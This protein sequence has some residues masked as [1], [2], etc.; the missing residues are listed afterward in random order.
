MILNDKLQFQLNIKTQD[1]FIDVSFEHLI[2]QK[3][4]SIQEKLIEERL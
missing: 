4:N 1:I 3:I 2:K